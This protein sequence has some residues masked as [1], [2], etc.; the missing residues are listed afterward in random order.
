MAVD[1]FEASSLRANEA[2]TSELFA[3][4]AN[5]GT[6][7]ASAVPPKS[8]LNLSFPFVEEEASAVPA[9]VAVCTNS[10]VASLV[11]LSPAD[12]VTPVVPRGRLG[13]PVNIG[14]FLSALASTAACNTMPCVAWSTYT[15]TAFWVGYSSLLVP[16]LVDVDLLDKLSL[17]ASPGTVGEEAVPPRSPANFTFPAAKVVASGT[18]V[19]TAS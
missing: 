13:V 3:F 18:P 12:C 17:V 9:A 11:E 14:E 6:V 16:K 8:P 2:F 4:R 15:L 10:V 1:L 7:G 5:P 19:P